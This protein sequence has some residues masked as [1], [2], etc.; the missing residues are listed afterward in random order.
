MNHFKHHLANSFL[1]PPQ[2]KKIEVKGKP[3]LLVKL[4]EI[5]I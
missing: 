4:T 5:S 1:P 3:K 2:K